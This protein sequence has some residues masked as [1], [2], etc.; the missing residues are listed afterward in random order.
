MISVSAYFRS[1]PRSGQFGLGANDRVRQGSYG[2]GY[3]KLQPAG[4]WLPG[5]V[6]RSLRGECAMRGMD[7]RPYRSAGPDSALLAEESSTGADGR[8]LLRLRSQVAS[9]VV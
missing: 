5:D 3:C 4:K 6:P 1:H 9:A 7:F 8:V 2:F